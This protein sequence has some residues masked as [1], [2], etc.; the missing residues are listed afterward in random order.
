MAHRWGFTLIELLIVVAIIAILA[1]IAVPNFLEAQARSKISR[2]KSDLRVCVT[3]LE[4][5]RV[6]SNQYP[7]PIEYDPDGSGYKITN[8]GTEE[9]AGVLPARLTTPVAYITTLPR[10]PFTHGDIDHPKNLPFHY[11]EQSNNVWFDPDLKNWIRDMYFKLTGRYVAAEY[12]MFSHAPCLK[13]LEDTPVLYDATNGTT[14]N[15]HVF[16]FG[17]GV[18]MQ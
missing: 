15:G 1:A 9:F 10:D 12:F 8:P 6:D 4:I 18:S 17:P 3:A 16:V 14:S 2:A 7:P 11:S 13:H 5:Y